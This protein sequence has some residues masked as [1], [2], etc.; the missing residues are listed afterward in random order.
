MHMPIYLLKQILGNSRYIEYR[1][2][3]IAI[4]FLG[5]WMLVLKNF[6]QINLKMSLWMH[7]KCLLYWVEK[8]KIWGHAYMRV[9]FLKRER[10]RA[11]PHPLLL[12]LFSFFKIKFYKNFCSTFN[13]ITTWKLTSPRL[14]RSLKM[15]HL[16]K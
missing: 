11:I 16:Y 8:I 2:M 7:K 13:C 15:P 14:R 5:T 12:H 4:A 3:N 6:R 1:E 10:S 9:Y